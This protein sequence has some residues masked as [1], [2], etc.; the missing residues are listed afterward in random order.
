MT[1]PAQLDV[2]A[3]HAALDQRRTSLKMSWRQAAAAAGISPST[4]TRLGQGKRPDMTSFAALVNW[5]GV[6]SE[7][8][9]SGITPT[10][11][12][13][14]DFLTVV[15]AHLRARKELSARSADALEDIIRAA[16][17]RLKE[18]DDES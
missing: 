14:Q 16:Y 10:K 12:H 8:F 2:Q 13:D 4:L 7:H 5:L 17:N 3:L 18:Q 9:L 1:D 15:S 6:S 11:R